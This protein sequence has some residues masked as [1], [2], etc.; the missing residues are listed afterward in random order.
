[1][2]S[3][4]MDVLNQYFKVVVSEKRALPSKSKCRNEEESSPTLTACYE[5]Y[6]HRFLPCILPWAKNITQTKLEHKEASF[7][8]FFKIRN[9]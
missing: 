6:V 3:T 1:M 2:N 7:V 5:D 9:A 4:H 8:S